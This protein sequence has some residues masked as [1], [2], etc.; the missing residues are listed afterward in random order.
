MPSTVAQAQRLLQPAWQ[1]EHRPHT[2]CPE[3]ATRAPRG[4]SV[5]PGPHS[6]T[7]PAISWPGIVPGATPSSPATMWRSVPHTPAAVTSTTTSPAAAGGAAT[8]SSSSRW[9]PR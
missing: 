5:T 4:Q 3:L 9:G 7:R 8:S 2:T 6:T 1:A